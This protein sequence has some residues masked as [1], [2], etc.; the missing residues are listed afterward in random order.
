MSPTQKPSLWAGEHL[1]SGSFTFAPMGAISIAA[2]SRG[3]VRLFFGSQPEML[4]SLGT[5]GASG[6]GGPGAHI[7]QDALNQVRAYLEGRR[8][9]F[10]LP[11]DGRVFTPFQKT[12]LDAVYAIPYGQVSTYGKIAAQVGKPGASRA[13]GTANGDNPLP[14]VIPCHRVVGSD[15]HL[16][17]YSAPGRLGWKAWL[18]Q[19]EGVE[20]KDYRLV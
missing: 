14:L 18:L 8:R 15:G 1:W 7:L 19:L 9:S 2:S 10:D 13:V 16:R 3:L 12:V 20:V 11:F 4:A 6:P 17:G 5:A